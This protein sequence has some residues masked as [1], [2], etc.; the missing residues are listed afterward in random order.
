MN[1]PFLRVA[2]LLTTLALAGCG[3][4]S[5]ET[6]STDV[7]AT[8]TETPSFT[9]T[10][11][12]S[13]N[14]VKGVIRNGRITAS[15]WANGHYEELASALTDDTGSYELTVSGTPGTLKIS[16]DLS[17][18]PEHPTEMRCDAPAGCG[19]KAYGEWVTLTEDLQLETWATLTES[20]L[21]DIAPMTALSTLAVR[22]AESLN[23]G[24][25]PSTLAFA[26]QRLTAALGIPADTL[27]AV[28]GDITSPLW[29]ATAGESAKRL[30]LLSAAFA[31]LSTTSGKTIRELLDQ[32]ATALADQNGHLVEA[33][34]DDS[35][36]IDR[37]LASATAV[38]QQAGDPVSGIIAM[39]QQ[40]RDGLRQDT[41]NTLPA[42]AID[43]NNLLN[44]LGPLGE[45][46][47]GVMS[48]SGA[49]TL[50]ALIL[51]E[52]N[53]F[54]WV[55]TT[56]TLVLAG[57]AI[58]I[59]VYGVIGAKFLDI[60]AAYPFAPSAIP[61]MDE[62][63]YVVTLH[64]SSKTMSFKGLRNGYQTDLTISIPRLSN[65]L[66]T[67]KFSV[68]ANGSLTG[69]SLKAAI[70][71]TLSIN[72][73]DTDLTGL[74]NAINVMLQGGTIDPSVLTS[75][76]SALLKT[77]HGTGS[78]GG[79]ASLESLINPGS[80]IAVAG[81]ASAELDMNGNNGGI[82]LSA[83]V[84]N[85]SLELPNGDRF[86]IREG[87]DKLA[88][89]MGDNINIDAAFQ[90]RVLTLP[91]ADVKGTATVTTAGKLISQGRDAV[92]TQLD[93]GTI[94]L[95]ELFN[96]IAALDFSSLHLTAAGTANI[97]DTGK[98]YRLSVD[99]S[100]MT[101]N[102]PN[103]TATAMTLG[104]GRQ[105]VTLAAGEYWMLFSPSFNPLG[106]TVAD[107]GGAES[108][109]TLESLLAAAP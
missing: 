78:L 4:D 82:S 44:A 1:N 39:F 81:N 35:A 57:N 10:G 108:L 67:G 106:I 60:Y 48:A 9:A 86:T 83:N 14:V 49:T 17:G 12:G 34:Q 23:S 70:N 85:G 6:A 25:N 26:R 102:Q 13:S 55:A 103:S 11:S 2:A 3:S 88:I 77:A 69:G 30:T 51:S 71:G 76:I 5:G 98:L 20:G 59:V 99:G 58:E 32:Y 84:K 63:G 80:K 91:L 8:D 18:D 64:P 73:L 27:T 29:L 61:L 36:S 90:A 79:S 101:I 72:A 21:L 97:P 47:R 45:D 100:T 74:A 50:E 104:L 107:S 54:R 65:A 87:V 96:A 28:P 62:N 68:G 75:S 38:G 109:L 94:N 43:T 52:L 7:P 16:F 53:Q 92:T 31:Q 24:L 40:Y 37:L 56:D 42:K 93:T 15:Q 95:G 22:Y 46:V 105:G 33:G 89:T 66:S 19:D 41:L